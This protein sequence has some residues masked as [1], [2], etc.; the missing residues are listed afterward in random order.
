MNEVISHRNVAYGINSN[1]EDN[2]YET[3]SPD[4]STLPQDNI[5]EELDPT[6]GKEMSVKVRVNRYFILVLVN[7]LILYDSTNLCGGQQK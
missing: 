5:E 4:D 1:R 6:T 2:S 7:F 3:V